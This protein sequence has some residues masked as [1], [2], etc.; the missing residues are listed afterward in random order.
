MDLPA[1]LH[2][3]WQGAAAIV[4]GPGVVVALMTLTP[5][6]AITAVAC[7]AAV[8]VLLLAAELCDGPPMT[9]Q[10][11]ARWMPFPTLAV[12]AFA[13]YHLL[14]GDW[15]PPV[16]A[17]M[18]ALG[19]LLTWWRSRPSRESAASWSE[20]DDILLSSWSQRWRDDDQAA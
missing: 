9:R 19:V 6:L 13:G 15:G 14:L 8:P 11:L 4:L 18:V 17:P 5:G 1:A 12:L 2:R 7:T 20:R 10:A 3:T 16:V